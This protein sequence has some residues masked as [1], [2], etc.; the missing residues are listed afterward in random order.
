VGYRPRVAKSPVPSMQDDVVHPV[1]DFE[2]MKASGYQ[3]I[4][5][6]NYTDYIVTQT[7]QIKC[8]DVTEA[9]ENHDTMYIHTIVAHDTSKCHENDTWPF[10]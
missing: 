10:E 6:V 4:I 8:N 5:Q 7:K 9:I 3:R 1:H 2:H